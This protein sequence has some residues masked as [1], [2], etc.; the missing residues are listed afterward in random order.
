MGYGPPAGY[1]APAG[2]KATVNPYMAAAS[3]ALKNQ[4][5]QSSGMTESDAREARMA[6]ALV[7][8]LQVLFGI[9]YLVQIQGLRA[10]LAAH[11]GDAIAN[12]L[13]TV[14]MYMNAAY[15]G[16]GVVMLCCAAMV[17]S[18]PR[19]ST[20]LGLIMYSLAIGFQAVTVPSSLLSFASIFK[21]LMITALG[22]A[23]INAYNADY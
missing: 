18:Y 20:S 21:I 12:Q 5:R 7:G 15:L 1:G 23:V 19:T 4:R 3:Q 14:A 9:I 11:Q 17:S 16:V 10:M 8:I 13:L 6:L 22:R 2:P